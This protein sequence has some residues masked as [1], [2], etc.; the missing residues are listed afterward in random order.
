VRFRFESGD[1]IH[2]RLSGNAPEL[3]CY[4]DAASAERAEQLCR[5]CLDRLRP[6][7]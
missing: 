3:R 7:L 2:L 4:T 6:Q 1:I 5:N